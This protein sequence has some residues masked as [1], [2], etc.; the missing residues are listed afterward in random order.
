MNWNRGTTL[1]TRI[2]QQWTRNEIESNNIVE[3]AR[4]FSNFRAIDQGKS[5]EL[6][7]QLNVAHPY[8]EK[9]A[10]LIEAAPELLEALK[11][12]AKWELPETKEFWD[13]E[14]TRPVS[15]ETQYGSN[16]VRDYIKSI[17]SKAVKLIEEQQ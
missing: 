4:I 11:Q 13:K 1:N 15:F 17:A 14:Q 5:R 9:N 12:I 16:G 8:Y 3:Q 7:C 10:K 2:T 6:V